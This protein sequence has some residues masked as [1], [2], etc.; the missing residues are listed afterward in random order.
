[1]VLYSHHKYTESL[2]KCVKIINSTTK[3]GFNNHERKHHELRKRGIEMIKIGN[4][5][6][7]YLG[8]TSISLKEN[9]LNHFKK[10]Q[11][12]YRARAQIQANFYMVTI[13]PSPL[14]RHADSLSE[15]N[16]A[17]S[18]SRRS[19]NQVDERFNA[20]SDIYA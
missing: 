18:I 8:F 1:M 12:R 16:N 4:N 9:V 7:P 5:R 10:S 6:W 20:C 15:R 13:S 19:M 3:S 17:F 14:H 11:V 2:K